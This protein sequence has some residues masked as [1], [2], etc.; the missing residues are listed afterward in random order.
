[1]QARILVHMPVGRI[2]PQ[3]LESVIGLDR[4]G[5][6][7]DDFFTW[8][9]TYP[10]NSIKWGH[11]IANKMERARNLAL[12]NY[13][14]L[15]NVESDIVVPRNAL[16][17]LLE[18]IH[19]VATGLYRLRPTH[20][21]TSAYG[22]RP[23]GLSRWVTEE[24][25]KDKRTLLLES[26]SFG[27]LLISRHVLEGIKFDQGIDS[28]FSASCKKKGY[29]MLLVPDVRCNHIDEDGVIYRC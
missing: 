1:M 20:S 2:V 6:V 7:V 21:G 8:H 11:N 13:D 18:E 17:R 14:Y 23:W 26:T 5:L 12:M 16:K 29:E 22:F 4:E 28:S 24:D 19:D 9:D 27:C 3:S 25:I 15:F 10:K